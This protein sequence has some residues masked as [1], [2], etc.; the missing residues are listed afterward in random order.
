MLDRLLADSVYFSAAGAV[1]AWCGIRGRSMWVRRRRRLAVRSVE[2]LID[3]EGC[4]FR[5]FGGQV[6][7]RGHSGNA[8]KQGVL[9]SRTNGYPFHPIAR[10]GGR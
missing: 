1:R 9:S 2:G 5:L 6:V 10:D 4:S 3:E 7:K 8:S